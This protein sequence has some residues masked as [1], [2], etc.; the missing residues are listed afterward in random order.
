MITT[1]SS[2]LL[3]KLP[4]L[5]SLVNAYGP[6][7]AVSERKP[8]VLDKFYDQLTKVLHDVRGSSAI[9][10][11]GDFNSKVGR[12]QCYEECLGKY[13]KGKRNANGDALIEF[14]Q[15]NNL[16]RVGGQAVDYSLSL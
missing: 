7:S 10:V 5:L 2:F 9:L 3:R 11:L 16:L 15:M 13:S 8:E 1:V 4:F 12:K 6:T 14:K